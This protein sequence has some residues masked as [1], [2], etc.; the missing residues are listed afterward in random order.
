MSKH[1]AKFTISKW[2]V[3]GFGSIAHLNKLKMRLEIENSNVEEL[4]KDLHEPDSAF[5]HTLSHLSH[6]YIVLAIMILICGVFCMIVLR[7]LSKDRR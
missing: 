5:K 4:I 1:I 2:S 7:S 3:E 6:A